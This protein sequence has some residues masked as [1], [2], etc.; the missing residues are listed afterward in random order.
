MI[1]LTLR[2]LVLTLTGILPVFAQ[3]VPVKFRYQPQATYVR[4]HFPGTFNNWGNNTNGTIQATDGSRADSLEAATGMWVK[5]IPLSPGTYEYKIYQQLSMVTTNWNWISDPLNRVKVSSYQ[6]SLLVVDNLVLFQICAYPYT[7]ETTGSGDRFVVGTNAPYLSAGIFRPAGMPPLTVS[8]FVDGQP[9]DS[10]GVYLDSTGIFT[11][12]PA[13]GLADGMHVFRLQVTDGVLTKADSVLF[14]VR[15][16]PVQIQTPSFVTRKRVYVTAGIVLKPDGSGLDSS[17]TSVTI[18]VN[19]TP[20]TIPV[21]NGKFLDSTSLAEGINRIRIASELGADSIIVTRVVDHAPFARALATLD[22]STIR[23]DASAT[24]DPDSQA[25]SSFTWL[26]DPEVP[27]G[28]NGQTGAIAS[29]TRPANPGEYYYGLIATDPDGHADTARLYFVV[30]EDGSVLNPSIADN[31][32]WAKRARVYFLFPKAATVQGTLAAAAQR[33]SVIRD[34]GFN[35][36]WLMPVMKNAYPIDNSVGVG[37]NITDFYTV[38]P[39][40]GTNQDLR[41]FVSQA[42]I[43]GLKVIL[44][45]TPNHTSRF[46]PWSADAHSRKTIS[47]YWNWYQHTI[48]P[49]NDNGLG[50][51]LD[52]DGFNYYS[53]FSDQLLNYNWTDVDARAQMIDVYK[54]WIAQFG[55][56]GYRFD[57]YWGPHRRYGEA[58]MGKPVRDALK[59]IKPDILLLAEDDGTGGSTET[60][61]AD[62]TNAGING[63][64]DAAY[65]FKLF[66]NQIRSFGFSADAINYL[67][68]EIYNGGYYPGPNSLYMRFMESQDEDRIAYVYS[69]NGY[70]DATTSFRRTMPMASVIFTVPGFPMIWNG[71]EVGWGYGIGGD[72]IA[73]S[74]SVINWSYAGGALL[75]PHYQKL[76]TIRG[77]FPAFAT[78]AFRRISSGSALVYAYTRPYH[79]EDAIVAVNFGPSPVST[80]LTIS[81]SDVANS[82]TE[83]KLVTVSDVYN[84]SISTTQ[85]TGGSVTLPVSLSAYGTSIIILSDSARH[86][87]F[88]P[89]TH[90]GDLRVPRGFALYPNYPNPFNPSTTIR[91]ELPHACAVQLRVFNLLGEEVTRLVDGRQSAGSYQVEWNGRSSSGRSVSSGIYF[92]HLQ[93]DEF[94]QTRKVIFVQ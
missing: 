85:V 21:L 31:P 59:H 80:S 13:N 45:I 2:F 84:D 71:Q 36:V 58:F 75:M 34:L 12:K 72:K 93:A 52:A 7:I 18:S 4:V 54:Y 24:V 6:N 25:V 38:A 94:S 53:G 43:L 56:D 86:V 77:Q 69:A 66:F 70:Y 47:P 22:G 17:V 14:E 10:T 64:V 61:Y 8:A 51:S 44:D 33:L 19:D 68:N 46:H 74:R 91:Y 9:V 88:A 32:S 42:H 55:V 49:H 63:G 62:Y 73:R 30:K 82:F 20:R 11:F 27:V 29:V 26:D 3:S 5:T 78:Q 23:L 83:G 48:I 87:T 65:D 28:L 15:A 60:I 89:L 92:V 37:Y 16:R 35:V 76:A 50:Q 40:Y 67:H 81:A 57:V 41:N 79:G 90:V 1:R 39:E